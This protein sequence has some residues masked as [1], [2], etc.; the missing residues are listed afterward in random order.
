MQSLSIIVPARNAESTIARCIESVTS[1]TVTDW[2]LTIVDDESDDS[3]STVVSS[4]ASEKIRL[5]RQKN[6]G[7]LSARLRG[8]A[9]TAS[10]WVLFIDADDELASPD[11]LTCLFATAERYPD[12][13]VI[14]GGEGE[15]RVV[16][17]VG[18]A[19]AMLYGDVRHE[20]WGTLFRRSVVEAVDADDILSF[21][22]GEDF[23]FMLKAMSRKC[24]VVV[25]TAGDV[26][27]YNRLRT[28]E[29]VW[30]DVPFFVKARFVA[31]LRKTAAD[32]NDE[33][34]GRLAWLYSLRFVYRFAVVTGDDFK[35]SH[36]VVADILSDSRR[37][38]AFGHD[39][40]IVT[41]L[42]HRSL[43]RVVAKRHINNIY[44]GDGSADCPAV[45]ILIPAHNA[46]ATIERALR[47]AL[48][49]VADCRF[50][51]VVYDDGS[52]DSTAEIVRSYAAVDSRVSLVMGEKNRGLSFARMML[53]DHSC[54]KW[55][56]FLDA[57]DLLESEAVAHLTQA[58]ADS[59]A[60]IVMMASKLRSRRFG[61]SFRYFIPTTKFTENPVCS[62]AMLPKFLQKSGVTL[63]V[64][65]KMYSR[66]LLDRVGPEAEE[67]F[68]G[69]DL[70]FNL[71]V[72]RKDFDV[73]L[74]DFAGYC[75]TTGG[76]S[77]I[78][79]DEKWNADI[80]LA[81]RVVER[82]RQLG[83]ATDEN[84]RAAVEGL[85]NS[86]AVSVAER[87]ARAYP[88]FRPK[89]PILPW[90]EACLDDSRLKD[91]LEFLPDHS[92]LKRRDS[93]AIFSRGRSIF[94]KSRFGYL[95]LRLM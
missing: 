67:K 78:D 50:E 21:R 39:R 17:N 37:F 63:N 86:L 77:W 3:T 35:S 79:S 24:G 49:Q 30:P 45:S 81:L 76:G 19:R 84:L 80:D 73:A 13:D 34:V 52:T 1:Q 22:Y 82:L 95:L 94:R 2:N 89:K 5:V 58:A 36:P 51:I 75:W 11:A 9:E 54:G 32:I 6:G 4:Y 90:I 85:E 60:E 28:E 57:D 53:L 15:P 47:S 16:D 44:I 42:R 31:A 74:I 59:R 71:R 38:A 68:Y 64:W 62:A 70:M 27:R 12:A 66:E 61:L 72:F 46:E 33:E 40:K 8:I 93:D 92:A 20:M 14:V 65:D 55:I 43:R 18:F 88:S 26:Y 56:L 7:P 10:E 29:M 69:E 83:I 91:L 25:G 87:L 41:L 23:L 48:A